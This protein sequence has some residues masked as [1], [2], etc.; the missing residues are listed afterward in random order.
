MVIFS[1][2]I[3]KA[4]ICNTFLHITASVLSKRKTSD[5]SNPSLSSRTRR[6]SLVR[7]YSKRG[8]SITHPFWFASNEASDFP[9]A[10]LPKNLY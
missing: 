6:I 9:V 4:V 10:A 1:I 5:G 3:P 8:V 2:I 7:Y